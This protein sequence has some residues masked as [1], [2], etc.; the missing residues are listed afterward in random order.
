MV[1]ESTGRTLADVESEYQSNERAKI[2]LSR[3]QRELTI[4]TGARQHATD[5]F[6]VLAPDVERVVDIFWNIYRVKQ[7]KAA[8]NLDYF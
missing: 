7:G 8:A 2:I 5:K 4:K 1:N 3:S 6:M